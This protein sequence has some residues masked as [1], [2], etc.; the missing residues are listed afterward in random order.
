VR[1]V[2]LEGCKQK[3]KPIQAGTKEALFESRGKQ[4]KGMATSSKMAAA[5]VMMAMLLLLMATAGESSPSAM[6]YSPSSKQLGARKLLQACIVTGNF[7]GPDDVC[8]IGFCGGITGS[9]LTFCFT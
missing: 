8:C 3:P 7:C 9:E 1:C 4:V 5:A 6:G 2:G